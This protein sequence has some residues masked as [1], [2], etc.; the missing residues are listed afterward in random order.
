MIALLLSKLG[1]KFGAW[2]AWLG[3]L[4]AA[5]FGL[6]EYGKH[7]QHAADLGEAAQ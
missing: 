1:A 2:F 5:V 6:I 3:A 4:A 7:K